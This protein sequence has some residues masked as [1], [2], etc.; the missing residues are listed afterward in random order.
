MKGKPKLKFKVNGTD[1][2]YNEINSEEV[3]DG[4]LDRLFEDV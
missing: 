1:C 3:L 4:M 2:E